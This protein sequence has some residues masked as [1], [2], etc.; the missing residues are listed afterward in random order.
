[1]KK[2]LILL[3]VAIAN[4]VSSK[5]ERLKKIIYISSILA[6]VLLVGH[7]V[8]KIWEEGRMVVF[9]AARHAEVY[10]VPVE[11]MVVKRERDILREPVTVRNGQ[12][13]VSAERLYKFRTGQRL[14]SGGQITAISRRIDLNTG[15]F[16]LR[17]SG[18]PGNHFAELPHTGIFVPLS[19]ISNSMVMV[20]ENGISAARQVDIIAEDAVRAVVDGLSENE[21]LIL[22][23]VRPGIKINPVIKR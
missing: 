12:I 18:A 23:R 2:I 20:S 21:I 13:S 16:T 7:R 14:T 1:M 22:T 15:L 19:A 17:A 8:Y 6:A 3:G 5:P 4:F 10:G 9:N 11:T